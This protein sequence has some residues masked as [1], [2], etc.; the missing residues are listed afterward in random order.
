MQHDICCNAQNLNLLSRCGRIST[1]IPARSSL[2]GLAFAGEHVLLQGSESGG[3]RRERGN[4]TLAKSPTTVAGAHPL[5]DLLFSPRAAFIWNHT[6]KSV[7][8]M[9]PAARAAFGPRLEDFSASLPASL[10]RRFTQFTERNAGGTAK[11]KILGVPGLSCSIEILKLA[12]GQDGLIVA[13]LSEGE[14]FQSTPAPS[15]SR[16]PAKGPKKTLRKAGTAHRPAAPRTPPT[17]TAEEMRAF[18]AVGRKV[19]RLCEDK[20]HSKEAAAAMPLPAP[21]EIACSPGRPAHALRDILAAF[22]LVLFLSESLDIV[23]IQGRAARLGLRKAKLAGKSVGDLM[24][25]YDRTVLRRMMKKLRG[26]AAYGSR[27]ALLI[28]GENGNAKPCRAILGRWEDGDA[29]FFLAL[30][31]MDL[32]ARLRRPQRAD[33]VA[34]ARLAA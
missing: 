28:C 8:W 33:S 1:K 9:N 23:G 13:E 19:L 11:V 20:K 29:A 32:P 16:K 17:L 31:S 27:D 6:R 24:L 25:P 7:A 34:A 14:E 2:S 30:H 26:Q 3:D 18:N 15:P 5:S 4:Q 12:D 21:S 10:I 22:D